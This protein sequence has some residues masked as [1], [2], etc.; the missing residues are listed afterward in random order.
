[1][2]KQLALSYSYN[3][4]TT[5]NGHASGALF[6]T[7]FIFAAIATVIGIVAMWKVFTKAGRP[8]WAAIIPIYNYWVLFEISGKPGWWALTALLGFIPFVGSLVILV[9]Y[10]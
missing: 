10:I 4:P 5:S 9:L 1:M 2:F 7:V 3:T 8:G 6:A